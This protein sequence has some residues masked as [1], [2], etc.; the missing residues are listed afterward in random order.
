MKFSFFKLLSEHLWI[1]IKNLILFIFLLIYLKLLILKALQPN[2][3]RSMDYIVLAINA[4]TFPLYR[5]VSVACL[6]TALLGEN[7]RDKMG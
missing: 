2:R 1:N 7:L 6:P 4:S 5:I 3:A